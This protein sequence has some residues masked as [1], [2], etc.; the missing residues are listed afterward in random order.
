VGPLF[1]TIPKGKMLRIYKLYIR[2][3]D[4]EI[5]QEIK[6]FDMAYGYFNDDLNVFEV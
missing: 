3:G 5:I 1:L 6:E 4:A 2:G